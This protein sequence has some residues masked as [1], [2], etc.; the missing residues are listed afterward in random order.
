MKNRVEV[1]VKQ[2]CFTGSCISIHRVKFMTER[3]LLDLVIDLRYLIILLLF[4]KA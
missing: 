4:D 1:L 2:V 3:I